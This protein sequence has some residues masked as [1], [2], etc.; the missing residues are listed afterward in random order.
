MSPPDSDSEHSINEDTD[1]DNAVA[2]DELLAGYGSP[3]DSNDSED[4]IKE[5]DQLPAP[6][7]TAEPSYGARDVR[8]KD[9]NLKMMVSRSC[10]SPVSVTDMP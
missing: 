8:L 5:E 9:P 1:Q 2:L 6:Q 4:S 10:G 3:L 7:Q